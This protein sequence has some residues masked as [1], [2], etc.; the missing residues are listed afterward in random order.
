VEPF[1]SKGVTDGYG[2]ISSDFVAL[3]FIFFLI[4]EHFRLHQV[5]IF[6]YFKKFPT[7]KPIL[8]SLLC[9]FVFGLYSSI[10]TSFFPTFSLVNLFK[11]QKITILF[12]STL[13]LLSSVKNGKKLL[14]KILSTALLFNFFISIPQFFGQLSGLFHSSL[15]LNNSVQLDD[16]SFIPRVSGVFL[17]PNEFGFF[18]ALWFLLLIHI[19]KRRFT[20]PI[21]LLPTLVLGVLSQ[22]RSVWLGLIICATIF[23]FKAIYKK[24][25]TVWKERSVF[26]KKYWFLLSLAVLILVFVLSPRLL[27]LRYTLNEGSGAIRVKMISEGWE[28]IQSS[29]LWGYGVGTNVMILYDQ[30]PLGSMIKFPREVHMAYIQLALEVGVVGA[31]FFFFPFL[32]LLYKLLKERKSSNWPL[33]I[34]LTFTLIYY[35]FQPHGGKLELP[36]LGVTLAYICFLLT[37]NHSKE[38]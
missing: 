19:D 12:L 38:M 27:A 1:L 20:Q 15:N 10:F 29:P 21:W 35:I 6:S 33:S 37:K 31:F 34:S 23:Q 32:F 25:K 13:I 2:F 36:L 14:G 18:I 7:L 22:S 11:Y 17:H 28:L 4:W 5:R 24:T 16:Q 9:F 30:F 3:G 26:L 8:W